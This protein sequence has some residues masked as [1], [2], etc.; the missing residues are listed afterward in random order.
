MLPTATAVYSAA[1]GGE[2]LD[3]LDRVLAAAVHRGS[4]HRPGELSVV[5]DVDR[6]QR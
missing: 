4:Y 3:R 1:S 6:D 2:P 5:R